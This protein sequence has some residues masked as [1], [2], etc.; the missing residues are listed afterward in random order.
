MAAARARPGCGA[1]GIDVD[2]FSAAAALASLRAAMKLCGEA[3]EGFGW[4]CEALA[5][6][7]GGGFELRGGEDTQRAGVAGGEMLLDSLL[8]ACWRVRRR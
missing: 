2:A 7:G 5:S 4:W 3:G 6:A 1:D 8:L